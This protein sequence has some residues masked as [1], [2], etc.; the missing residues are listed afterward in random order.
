MK[1]ETHSTLLAE[2]LRRACVVTKVG[3]KPRGNYATDAR[4]VAWPEH[5]RH[6]DSLSLVTAGEAFMVRKIQR[7][8]LA[9]GSDTVGTSEAWASL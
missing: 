5:C 3:T 1:V 7:V 6:H 8:R 9:R 2:A 4:P